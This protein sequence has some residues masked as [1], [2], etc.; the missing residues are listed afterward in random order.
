MSY[1]QILFLAL[2]F[3]Q[4]ASTS[5]LSLNNPLPIGSSSHRYY[6]NCSKQDA[7]MLVTTPSLN[8]KNVE[9]TLKRVQ[10]TIPSAE[11]IET[12][13]ERDFYRVVVKCF[14]N[15]S[16]AKLLNANLSKNHKTPFVVKSNELYC[17]VASSQMTKEAALDD[18]KKLS[19]KHLNTTIVKMSLPLPHWQIKISDY[20]DLRDTV[21]MANTISM[22]GLMTTIEPTTKVSPEKSKEVL[23]RLLSEEISNSYK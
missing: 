20:C 5:A 2:F 7:Y 15:I 13:K 19:T 23:Y 4:L 10:T 6:E 14:K 16:D 9:S 8:K 11:L 3:I 21:K 18:Q 12:F 22:N 1:L 17:V